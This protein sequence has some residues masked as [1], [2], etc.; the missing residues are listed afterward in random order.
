MAR[1]LMMTIGCGVLAGVA[2]MSMPGAFV[3]AQQPTP[4]KRVSRQAKAAALAADPAVDRGR[5]QF[6]QSCAFCHGNDA[7][8]GRGPDLMRSPVVAHDLK[9]DLIGVVVRQGRPDKGMPA[10]PLSDDQVADVAAFL[11]ALAA[12]AIASSEVP[13]GYAAQRLL[14]GSATA[15]KAYFNGAGGCSRCHSGEWHEL[16]AIFAARPRDSYVVSGGALQERY[17]Y[18][19]FRRDRGGTLGAYR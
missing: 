7:T 15:G 16:R 3:R 19:A 4:V 13:E 10:L 8:G 2:I 18:A 12:Q 11:H 5:K 17:G 6:V 1:S 14:T 9:G